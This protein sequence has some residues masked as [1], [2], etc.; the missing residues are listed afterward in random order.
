MVVSDYKGFLQA[1]Q[2]AL[3]HKPFGVD[4]LRTHVRQVLEDT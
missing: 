4:E 2:R 3:L 1:V